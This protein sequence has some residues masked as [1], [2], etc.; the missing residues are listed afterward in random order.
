MGSLIGGNHVQ[1][2]YEAGKGPQ[3]VTVE[4]AYRLDDDNWHSVLVERNRKEA[5][6]VVDG[7][8]KGQVKEPRGPVRPMLLNNNLYVGAKGDLTDGF[9]GCMRALV[10]NG[11]MVDL[12]GEAKKELYGI[13]LGC[14]GKCATNPCMNGGECKEQYSQFECDCRWTPFKGPICADEI[15]VNMRTNYMIKYDFKGRY[16]STIAER[17]HVGFTTTDPKGFLIGA[18]SDISQEYLTLMVSNSGHI[19]LV[20]DFGFERQEMVFTEQSFMTGQYHD[21]RIERFDQG[22][23]MMMTIDNH[24]PQEYDFTNSL[25]SSAD[26]QF[27]NIRYLYIG[28]NES[29]NEGFVGCIS[30]VEFDEIIPLKL[31]FQEDPHDNINAIPESITEDFCGIEPVTLKPEEKETRRPPDI[32]QEKIKD[33]YD[34]T[35]SVILGVIL[36]LIFFLLLL[37]CIGMGKYMNRHKGDYYTQEDEGARDAFDADTAVLQGRTGH[38][39]QNKKEWFI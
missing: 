30:R 27:N 34:T 8:R 28:K 15:G 4:T 19:R 25:K 29:M 24:A 11:A 9:V 31:Y 32:D 21:V 36:S 14:V 7:A 12:V 16:K 26:A 6:V 39:V 18:F 22:R 10:L 1:L 33:F 37:V 2:E 13:G 5:M 35:S 23:K 38:Q 20:F 3:A 17:I